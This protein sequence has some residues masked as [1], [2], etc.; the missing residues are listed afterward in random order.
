MGQKTINDLEI[1]D[2]VADMHDGFRPLAD[3]FT[4][5]PIDSWEHEAPSDHFPKPHAM[6]KY[7][8]VL[9][10]NDE[11]E[12]ICGY[13][14]DGRYSALFAISAKET[15]IMGQNHTVGAHATTVARDRTGTLNI[16]YHST[17]VVS[18]ADDGR[19]TLDS[20][21]HRTST[22][23]TRMNQAARQYGLGFEVYQRA[24]AWYV[25]VGGCVL[26]FADGMAFGGGINATIPGMEATQ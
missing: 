25:R 1:G 21:G 10:H 4:V 5:R 6:N 13:Q 16:T 7:A 18:V 15:V 3:R 11:G 20:G 24:R 9:G 12:L 23:K 26:P 14:Y 19:I 17:V 2:F 8:Y 22:T